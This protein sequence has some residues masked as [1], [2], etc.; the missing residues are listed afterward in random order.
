MEIE[1]TSGLKVLAIGIMGKFLS[2]RDNNMKY[3]SLNTLQQIVKIDLN[4][5][6][7]HKQTILDCLK[8]TDISIKKQALELLYVLI[9]SENFK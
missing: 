9:N 2:H 3:V 1:S 5:V 4:A 6:Q 8:D 7:R